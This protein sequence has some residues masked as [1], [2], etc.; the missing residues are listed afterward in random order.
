MDKFCYHSN[1]TNYNKFKSVVKQG[2]GNNTHNII[3]DT[4]NIKCITS[5]IGEDKFN[6]L[7]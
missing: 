2:K 1:T 4:I 5:K 7:G 6:L 3:M